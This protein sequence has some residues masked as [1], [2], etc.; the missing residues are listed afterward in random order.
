MKILLLIV[1]LIFSSVSHSAFY[2]G[3][4]ILALCEAEKED[5]L[6]V[7]DL[8]WCAGY[9]TGV[10]DHL[11]GTTKEGVLC[12]N[13]EIT[14]GQV[15]KIFVAYANKNPAELNQSAYIVVYN[16]INDAFNC[17]QN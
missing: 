5:Q 4:E 3:N 8:S 7:E 6:F 12:L 14:V 1:T 13:G 9:L 11:A 2:S 16:S 17:N 10:F 15:R